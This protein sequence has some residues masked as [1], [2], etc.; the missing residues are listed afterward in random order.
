MLLHEIYRNTKSRLA[1][2]HF[3]ADMDNQSA[4]TT[5]PGYSQFP[6]TIVG[7]WDSNMAK[8]TFSSIMKGAAAQPQGP[9]P[10][11]KLLKFIITLALSVSRHSQRPREELHGWAVTVALHAEWEEMFLTGHCWWNDFKVNLCYTVAVLYFPF[12]LWAQPLNNL[13]A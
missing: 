3:C 10:K 12:Q 7:I 8:A 11:P 9:L 6:C 4:V 5:L 13:G 1:W 2:L